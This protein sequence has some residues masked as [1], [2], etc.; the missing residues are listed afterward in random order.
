MKKAILY[1]GFISLIYPS[2]FLGQEINKDVKVVREYN[3]IISDANKINQ[4]PKNEVDSSKFT[5]DFTYDILTKAMT[6][7]LAIEPI[8]AARLKPERKTV[9]DK[10]YVRGGLGNY[11]TFFG[12]LDYNVLRSEDYA[13]GLNI[14]HISSAG[15][16]KL[17]DDSKVS[18]PFHDT[19]SSLY[20]RRF[21]DDYTL[22]IDAAFDHNIFNY[23]G[24]QTFT[25]TLSYYSPLSA[26]SQYEVPG[27]D[28]KYED[29]QRLSSFD[30]N[31]G[32]QNK[33]LDGEDLSFDANLNFG[34]FGNVTGVGENVFGL[35]GN[36]RKGFDN[37]F[38]DVNAGV[39]YFGTSVPV[40][41][42]LFE[43]ADRNMTVFTLCPSV[44]FIFEG[45]NLQVGIDTYSNL[46]G[47]NDGF[48]I[49]PHLLADF[50]IADGIVTAFGGVKGDYIVNDYQSVQ[51]ENNFISPDLNVQNSFHGIH[52]LGG[53]KG[54]FSAQTSFV[55]RVDYS[56]FSDEHFFV[57]KSLTDTEGNIHQLNVFDVEYDDGS[58]LTV[59]GEIKY[60]ASNK[61][62]VLLKGKYNGW[63]LDNL[64]K[65]WHKPDMELGVT[66]NFSPIEDL[67]C[68]VGFY[69]QGKRYVKD[70]TNIEE[71][72]VNELEPVYDLR[73]G[74]R[75]LLSSKWTIFGNI[76][77]LLVS[78]YYEWNGYPSQ[79]MNV[80][81]GVG[82]SF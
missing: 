18:A 65:A 60:E 16:I 52:L 54:N 72:G 44:G 27:S 38:I 43:Y 22:S 81:V 36:I 80:R 57:N 41:D 58:L 34:T 21:W 39:Q 76:N 26:D 20:F 28:L 12:E 61:L 35:T 56:M 46:G 33:V 30:V 82:Y 79:G 63:N 15:D 75:Y 50:V 66:A 3:P 13:V 74:A 42:L 53:I 11:T 67:W 47:E 17:E 55:A 24:Y 70:V 71:V 6:S 4:L 64:E 2:T 8:T 29:R 51:K 31:V 49:A 48:N 37:V 73:L 7:E 59:S 1:L 68:N 77:N 10:S 25:D 45:I 9:L 14:G 19:W 32:F 69:S 5:P 62:N 23:Y 40:S 78:K